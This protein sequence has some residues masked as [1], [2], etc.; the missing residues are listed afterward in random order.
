ETPA[1]APVTI[2]TTLVCLSP[3]FVSVALP[4]SPELLWGERCT[5]RAPFHQLLTVVQP[6]SRTTTQ[7]T[8]AIVRARRIRTSWGV[9]RKTPLARTGLDAQFHGGRG[10]DRAIERSTL[11]I[12]LDERLRL[13]LADAD[14]LEA[15]RDA[16]EAR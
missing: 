1:G 3:C 14:Q 16:R 9:T 6:T 2:R 5:S 4:D 11:A 12:G 8:G 10:R 15:H 13:G 7:S